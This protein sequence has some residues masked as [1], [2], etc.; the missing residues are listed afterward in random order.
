MTVAEASADMDRA[1]PGLDGDPVETARDRARAAGL[2]LMRPEDWPE[3]ISLPP[4]LSPAFLRDRRALPLGRDAEGR[5]LVAVADPSDAALIEALGLALGG[6]VALR[7][8]SA[9]AILGRLAA[10]GGAFDGGFPDAFPETTGAEPAE[11]TGDSA[12]DA[13]VIALWDRLLAE[14]VRA[15]ATD[16][17]L[18]PGPQAMT[19]RHRV[20]GLLRVVTTLPPATG[21][22]LV[23]RLK[24]LS[25]LNIA[26]RRLAQDGHIR[27]QI[28]GELRDL[29]CAT[30]PL[31]DGEGAAVRILAART[32]L[33]SVA[34]LGLR[35]GAEG[36]LRAALAQSHG[37]ILVTGPTGSGKTTTLAA[38]TAEI[39]QPHR[40]I[41]S[42]EDP[43]EYRIPG[44]SQMQVNPQIGLSFASALRSFLRADPDVILVGE[45][46]DAETA[47]ITVQA[48]LTGHLVLTTL[49]TNSAADAV[50][51]MIDM[52]LEPFLIAA[53]L[54]C[55]VGQRLVRVLCRRC[56]TPV[57]SVPPFAD[58]ALRAAG[59]EPG[60]EVDC[61]AATGCEHCGHTG[62]Y[63]R[64]A[65][66]EVMPM[67]A[68][69]R[70]LI[71]RGAPGPAL[72]AEAARGGMVPMVADGILRALAGQTTFEEVLRVAR[73]G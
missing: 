26:E 2:P 47:R 10:L 22:A 55:A 15:R 58:T 5:A 64:V 16:L 17:H 72:A 11:D 28:G 48:A 14:A 66:F 30:L 23:S 3:A 39:N 59:L 36:D 42:I 41:L 65:L 61:W 31:V 54:R 34:T 32:T 1:G 62:Y 44:V 45:V 19:V 8:A 49:H 73:D 46:R 56:K 29:R 21:R 69:L 25:G 4:G 18:E 27:A 68:E 12:L 67:T 63:G 50:V 24:I 33:P 57:R 6:P 13:P 40:K 51:R 53:T 70:A 43:V 71:L 52:G 37:L 35:A 38:A 7:V 9:P 20:D 60:A